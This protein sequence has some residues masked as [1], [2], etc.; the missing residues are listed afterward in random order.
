MVGCP[1]QAPH[2]DISGVLGFDSRLGNSIYNV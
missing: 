1:R 2:T